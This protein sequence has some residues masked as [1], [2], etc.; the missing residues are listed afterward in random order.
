METKELKQELNPDE[1]EQVSGG[2]GNP[3]S[4]PDPEKPRVVISIPKA[5]DKKENYPFFR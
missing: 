3:E 1:M 2:G 4:Q 5:S